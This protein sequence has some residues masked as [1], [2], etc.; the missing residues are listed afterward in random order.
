MKRRSF[1][2]FF[3]LM[4]AVSLSILPKTLN[5]QSVPSQ[6]LTLRKSV[7]LSLQ[8]GEQNCEYFL[9][10]K[11]GGT[12]QRVAFNFADKS[13]A[14]SGDTPRVEYLTIV[15]SGKGIPT[16]R[17]V[18]TDDNGQNKYELDMDDDTYHANAR[19]LQGV[20]AQSTKH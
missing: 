19:C 3:V 16:A 13:A 5:T 11:L 20:P 18:G 2:G 1:A 9:W 8:P 10:T 15:I 4:L 6:Q 14:T 12:S 17:I 7:V